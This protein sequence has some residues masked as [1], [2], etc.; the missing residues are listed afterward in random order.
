MFKRRRDEAGHG[1]EPPA[2]A[3][4]PAGL[5]PT[6]P[7]ETRDQPPKPPPERRPASLQRSTPDVGM[8]PF[9]PALQQG[10]ATA[11][12]RS[13]VQ[14]PV[15][16]QPAAARPAARAFRPAP[17]MQPGRC[18]ASRLGQGMPAQASHAAR[19]HAARRNAAARAPWPRDRPDRRAQQCNGG[20]AAQG[21]SP[22]I[23]RRP[24]HQPA[25]PDP[26][27]RAPRRRRHRRGPAP[28]RAPN[29]RSPQAA[30]SRARSRSRMPRSPASSTAPS[31]HAAI[32]MV[33]ST[34]KRHRHSALPPAAGR[35][36][37]ADERQDGDDHRRCA[38]QGARPRRLT[39]PAAGRAPV[40]GR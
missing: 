22:H 32:S 38:D 37:R 24:R 15:T 36:W 17:P 34:G 5:F 8:P 25:R 11:M 6:P 4:P 28:A 3:A 16:A 7:P 21:G 29:S 1:D 27:R 26:G 2:D 33:R 13:P 35:G 40:S 30:C 14:H 12:A 9:R 19:R 31:P 23:G 10:T 39:P 18:P 20:D